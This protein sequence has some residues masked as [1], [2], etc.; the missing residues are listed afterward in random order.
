MANELYFKVQ[1]RYSP[2]NSRTIP[3]AIG[4]EEKEITQT[5]VDHQA[6]TQSIGTTEETVG[7]S[8]DIGD[9]GY[10]FVKNLDAT[11]F[12]QIGFSTGVYGMRLYPG[13]F[14]LFRL[15]PGATFYAKADTAAITLQ[16]IVYEN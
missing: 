4:V 9:E 15:E 14:A 6:G 16:Y 1:G 13:E 5:G 10:M 3:V 7:W 2:A 12:V 11:N 8:S